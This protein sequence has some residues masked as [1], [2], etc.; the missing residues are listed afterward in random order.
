MTHIKDSQVEQLPAT[1]AW[2]IMSLATSLLPPSPAYALNDIFKVE[3]SDGSWVE[4]SDKDK[5]CKLD[6]K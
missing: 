3:V 2:L 5:R 1:P 6:Y 4:R